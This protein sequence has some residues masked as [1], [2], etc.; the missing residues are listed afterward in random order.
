MNY[1]IASA[2]FVSSFLWLS[3]AQGA[4]WGDCR[5]GIGE[6]RPGFSSNWTMKVKNGAKC[7][8]WMKVPGR[9]DSLKVI[10]PAKFGKASVPNR[11][12]VS[13]QAKLGYKGK[14]F[15]VFALKESGTAT[16]NIDVTVF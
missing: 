9:I 6:L 4:D 12:T 3:P 14:D 7:T 8:I 5:Y 15:F 1:R 13:Y 2:L 16:V 10:S 11:F